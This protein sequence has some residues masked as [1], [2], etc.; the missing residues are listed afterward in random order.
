MRIGEWNELGRARQ[1]LQRQLGELGA[2]EFAA[3]VTVNET[4]GRLRIF[5]ATDVGLL[6]YTYA[7]AGNNPEGDWI[8]RGS[9]VRW[10]SVKALRL[11]TDAQIDEETQSVRSLWRLVAEEPKVELSASSEDDDDRAVQALLAFAR[12]CLQHAG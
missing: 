2:A 10:S 7:P 8:L 12:A 4:N 3:H 5:V 1:L 11:Q 6:E 9:L